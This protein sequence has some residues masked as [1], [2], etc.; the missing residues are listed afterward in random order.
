MKTVQVLNRKGRLIR[1]YPAGVL[2]PG[3]IAFGGP[4]FD[5]LFITG[6]LGAEGKS[7]GALMRLDVH[8]KGLP[9]PARGAP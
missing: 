1:Q 2:T 4:K 7:E 6:A 3:N 9:L 5:Q 8:M